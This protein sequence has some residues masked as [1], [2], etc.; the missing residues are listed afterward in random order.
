MRTRDTRFSASNNILTFYRVRVRGTVNERLRYF[1]VQN[2]IGIRAACA[3][4][5]PAPRDASTCTSGGHAHRS[6]PWPLPLTTSEIAFT[7][8]TIF[9]PIC[10]T[11]LGLQFAFGI[12][13]RFAYLSA[14]RIRIAAGLLACGLLGA[15]DAE[16]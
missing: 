16:H 9:T 14:L 7:Q 13:S 12:M 15:L 3:T 11:R 6:I 8:V 1:A 2:A 5:R 10:V 4:R